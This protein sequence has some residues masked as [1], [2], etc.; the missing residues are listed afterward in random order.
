MPAR[1]IRAQLSEWVRDQ[2]QLESFTDDIGWA[3][4]PQDGLAGTPPNMHAQM[5]WRVALTMKTGILDAAVITDHDSILK[6]DPT[7]AEVRGEVTKLSAQGGAIP[8]L[9]PR[10]AQ[11]LH[12]AGVLGTA[13]LVNW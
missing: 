7:E 3:V 4:Y 8:R 5:H 2:V 12:V 11:I 6:P 13:P 1:D 10:P 9:A